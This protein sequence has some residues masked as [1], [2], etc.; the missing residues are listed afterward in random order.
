MTWHAAPP[1]TAER[2]VDAVPR[3]SAGHDPRPRPAPTPPPPSGRWRSP[4]RL[5][6]GTL[7]VL[8]LPGLLNAQ[9]PAS[10]QAIP[11]MRLTAELGTRAEYIA[12]ENFAE[13]DAVSADDHRFRL[14]LRF[15]LA[16][17]IP[18][19][20]VL[21]A[22]VRLSTGE[23]AFPT[24]AWVTPA[25]FRR[26]PIQ[27]DRAY[28]GFRVAD[29][30]VMRA[31]AHP[32]PLFTPTELVWDG[33]VQPV[34]LSQTVHFFRSSLTLAA[35]QYA[36]RE[37]RSARESNAQSA[38][39]LAHG[40]SYTLAA[41][42]ASTTMGVAQYYFHNADVLARSMQ[43]G[44]LDGEFRTNR[45]HPHGRT[46]PDPRNPAQRLPA[47]YFSGYN[48]VNGGIRLD[49]VRAPLSLAADVALN[50]G[51][52]RNPALGEPF[53][54]RENVAAGGMLRHGRLRQPGDRSV[55]VGYFYIEAD[56]V[57][58][59]YNSDDL[60]Q[61]NVRSVPLEFQVLLPGR[62]RLVWD[63]YLQR[64]LNPAL[65]SNGGVVHPENALKV[66]S[67]I[68]AVASF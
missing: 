12:N 68:S 7:A 64:K 19:S 43:V 66:R 13:S 31:G 63:T 16:G 14:R 9:A 26:L 57:L 10:E 3:S 52:N 40:I 18:L 30:A 60:Q 58:A 48:I 8:F 67:R 51:G 15:R 38:Y 56:A 6:T 54:R 65:A 2:E 37:T 50:L 33:D 59:T 36:I 62:T 49:G 46:V 32:S 25:D 45:Y 17:V 53:R 24:S 39:L 61:T 27:I 11:G 34:G 4:G 20:D 44:E 21:E 47:D 23:P 1:R 29:R 22:G 55:G 42:Q 35:G 41:A 28:L 5:A